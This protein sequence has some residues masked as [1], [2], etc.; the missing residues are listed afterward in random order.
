MRRRFSAALGILIGLMV[1]AGA[2]TAG[3]G[4]GQ[5]FFQV[6]IP[7]PGWVRAPLDSGILGLAGSDQRLRLIGPG[8]RPIPYALLGGESGTIPVQDIKVEETP[9]GWWI[10]FDLG[11]V[12][13]DHNHLFFNPARPTAAA[14]CRLEGSS[15]RSTWK[16]L[17]RGDL[18]RIGEGAGLARSRFDYP[19]TNVR[20]LRLSWPKNAGFPEVREAAVALM[21]IAPDAAGARALPATEKTGVGDYLLRLPG[22]GLWVDQVILTWKAAAPPRAELLLAENG[23][24]HSLGSASPGT[25]APEKIIFHFGDAR[26]RTRVLRLLVQGGPFQ[27]EYLAPRRWILFDAP[28]PGSYILVPGAPNSPGPSPG[29]GPAVKGAL[30]EAAFV[31]GNSSGWDFQIPAEVVRPVP[32]AQLPPSSMAFKITAPEPLAEGTPVRVPLP[33]QL[34]EFPGVKPSNLR[35]TVGKAVIP[36]FLEPLGDPR[37]VQ[38]GTFGAEATTRESFSWK[39]PGRDWTQ[40]ELRA[41]RPGPWSLLVQLTFK[42]GLR[43]GG[44]PTSAW[45]GNWVCSDEPALCPLRLDIDPPEGAQEMVLE[46]NAPNNQVLPAPFT[47]RVWAA[48]QALRFAWPAKGEL[49]LTSG[50]GPRWGNE[51]QVAKVEEELGHRPAQA[52]LAIDLAAVQADQQALEGRSKTA[53]MVVIG[54]AALVLLFVLGRAISKKPKGAAGAD[55]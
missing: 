51:P 39:K 33:G 16:P 28:Q 19:R 54:L 45:S 7:K 32:V 10:S 6:E 14:G 29:I 20:Y 26:L 46:V 49:R 25:D 52:T 24:W 4:Q 5:P 11:I 17:A 22:D 37:P 2:D 47:A 9:E 1:L 55:E 15:D 30:S 50:F 42:A 12:P 44:E 8:N 35:P 34:W 27:A 23:R 21:E 13:Q 43:S 40:I 48:D 38:D 31:P 41:Q 53:L 18:F 3:A 36:S